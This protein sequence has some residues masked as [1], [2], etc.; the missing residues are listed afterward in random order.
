MDFF[1]FKKI[2]AAVVMPLN[3]SLLL[4]I[5]AAMFF[6]L[7]PKLSRT[8]LIL[9]TLIL[10]ISSITP[11][12]DKTIAPFEQTYESFS[13]SI[14]PI[15]YIVVLGCG[16]A[17]NHALPATSQLKACSLRRLIEGMRVLKLHP[18]AKL[19]V[20]GYGLYDEQT[21]AETV[22]KAAIALGVPNAKIIVE[23]YPKDTRE[24]AQLIA[25]RVKGKTTV[26]VTD[27]YHLPRAMKYF[28]LEGVKPIPA[29]A[30]YYA[31]NPDQDFV[32]P[33]L[34]PSAKNLQT[35]SIVWYETMGRIWQWLAY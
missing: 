23:P 21:N 31:I 34:V 8:S 30:G 11:V 20:S 10:G 1:L 7:K 26:L 33:H 2:I 12:A 3:I 14:K 18:E 5:I 16:H 19:I 17:T 28:E 6:K 13:R 32:W 29:P 4:L 15:S 24:E 27:A 22:Q 35:S 9:G 25:P